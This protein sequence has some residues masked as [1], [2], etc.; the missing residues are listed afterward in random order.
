VRREANGTAD[1]INR[2]SLPL[3]A[4]LSSTTKI[5]ITGERG[6]ESLRGPGE[7]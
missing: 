6:T 5:E 2:E 4:A 1:E 3:A 7:P